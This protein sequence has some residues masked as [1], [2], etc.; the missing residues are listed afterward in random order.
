MKA[1]TSAIS[2]CICA[3]IF[4][5]V[6]QA[7]ST[8]DLRYVSASPAGIA[9]IR[10]PW[11]GTFHTVYAGQYNLQLDP[12]YVRAAD[13]ANETNRL[14]DVAN[15]F[16]VGTFCADINEDAPAKPAGDFVTYDI[17][18]PGDAPIGDHNTAMSTDQANALRRLFANYGSGL[19][20][21]S[22]TAFALCVWEI[23]FERTDPIYSV[24]NGDGEFYA[25]AANTN[26]YDLANFWLDAVQSSSNVPDI[27]LRVLANDGYQDFAIVVSDVSETPPAVPEPITMLGLLMGVGGLAGYIRKRKTA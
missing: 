25:S 22:A 9:T 23:V 17:I 2:V 26:A 27:A 24:S 13:P 15:N 4:C 19:D 11:D 12:S 7:T 6:A 8:V 18:M 21:T 14:Y 1:R 20:N 5:G 3:L 10:R 16:M